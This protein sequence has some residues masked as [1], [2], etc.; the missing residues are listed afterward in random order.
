MSSA[1]YTVFYFDAF[2]GRAEPAHLM[3]AA[4]NASFEKKG[5][6]DL[7]ST[8]FQAPAL[9]DNS[10]G[11]VLGQ[12]TVISKFL[13]RRLGF[14][15]SGGDEEIVAMKI[16]DDIADI[17]SEGYSLRKKSDAGKCLEWLD[18]RPDGTRNRGR[19]VRLLS[20]INESRSMGGLRGQGQ[21]FLTGSEV[22]YV[23]F[24]FLNAVRVMEHCYGADRVAL[25]LGQQACGNLKDVVENVKGLERLKEYL[26][27]CP[28]VL[29]ESVS[30]AKLFGQTGRRDSRSISPPKPPSQGSL[31]KRYSKGFVDKTVGPRIDNGPPP[32]HAA[33]K[34]RSTI[35]VG[36]LRTDSIHDFNKE[37][38]K[39]EKV[40]N[41]WGAMFNAAGGGKK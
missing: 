27:S 16:A 30:A 40:E 37:Q 26:A 17:W 25:C 31:A 28:P 21:T 22:K 8:A 12:T 36:E 15:I 19:F 39:T 41:A 9:R 4:A 38:R 1:A 14:D 33:L 20:V 34:K 6:D 18:V 29:Y 35:N 5:K 13:G 24:L 23:D 2:S 3:L 11:L 32:G 10:S 7:P